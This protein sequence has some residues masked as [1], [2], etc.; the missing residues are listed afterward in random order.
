MT[1]LPREFIEE[2][3]ELRNDP[4]SEWAGCFKNQ[5]KDLLPY[6]TPNGETAI[7]PLRFVAHVR[8]T[9]ERRNRGSLEGPFLKEITNLLHEIG[10]ERLDPRQLEGDP[11]ESTY[12]TYFMSLRGGGSSS[13]E[14]RRNHFSVGRMT[15]WVP[16]ERSVNREDVIEVMN[17]LPS[18]LP[19]GFGAARTWFVAHP[20][21]GED[22]PAK[23]VW[24]LAINQPGKS[25]HAHQARDALRNLGFE[26]ANLS[27][28]PVED[29]SVLTEGASK[30]VTRNERERSKVARQLCLDHYE[31][32]YGRIFC[33]ACGMDFGRTYGPEG[34]GFIHVH[35]L[36]PLAETRTART[37]SPDFDLVPVCPNCHAMIHKGGQTRTIAEIRQMMGL[38]E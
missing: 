2:L 19:E 16:R 4:F 38:Q 3:E 22:L 13:I 17:N 37:V 6:Q 11:F 21:T 35:H 1:D 24:G 32:K 25:F 36:N 5:S 9:G 15:W 7:A 20:E 26:V 14:V 18:E 10:Y 31:A 8:K 27:E 28:R 12:R 34:V 33:V 23:L 30:Q 29:E